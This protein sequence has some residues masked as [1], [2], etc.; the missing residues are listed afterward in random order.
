MLVQPRDNLAAKEAGKSG[1]VGDTQ[2]TPD[3]GGESRWNKL[4][5]EF[6]DVFEPPG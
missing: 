6:A 3:Q 1:D 5:E 4:V 2:S